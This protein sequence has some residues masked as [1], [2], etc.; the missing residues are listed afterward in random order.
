[1]NIQYFNVRGILSKVILDDEKEPSYCE[2]YDPRK[3][4][5]V[6]NNSILDDLYNHSDSV[7]ISEEEFNKRLDHYEKKTSY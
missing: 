3:S 1:M 7:E 6:R 4:S 2:T 5:F